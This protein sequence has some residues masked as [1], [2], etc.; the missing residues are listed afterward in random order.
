MAAVREYATEALRQHTYKRL[1]MGQIGEFERALAETKAEA[2]GVF[3]RLGAGAIAVP[4]A[5]RP[6]VCV[7]LHR[8][9]RRAPGSLTQRRLE[10]VA[11]KPLTAEDAAR[12]RAIAAEVQAEAEAAAS[13][14][15]Q[16]RAAEDRKRQRQEQAEV[17][18]TEAAAKRR[19]KEER[20]EARRA[21]RAADAALERRVQQG[22]RQLERAG[23]AA[24][25]GM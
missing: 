2:R 20:E 21:K 15:Q 19:A 13:K 10:E 18:R 22:A 7:Y 8:V 6:G 14:A 11:T 17:R 25:G 9:R 16:K 3:E 4:L 5:E 24:E 23:A 12:L 1:A